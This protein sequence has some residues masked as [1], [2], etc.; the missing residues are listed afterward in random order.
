MH[1][2]L[3]KAMD[4]LDGNYVNNNLIVFLT[5]LDDG[6]AI[7]TNCIFKEYPDS[8]KNHAAIGIRRG[9]HGQMATTTY[10]ET[11][12]FN[13]VAKP[14]YFLDNWTDGKILILTFFSLFFKEENNPIFLTKMDL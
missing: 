12:T 9:N 8:S 2:I 4:L 3:C 1:H 6:T 14:V 5:F 11:S 13:N 10:I 7:M